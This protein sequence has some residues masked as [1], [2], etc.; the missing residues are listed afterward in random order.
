MKVPIAEPFLGR[1][2]ETAI[3]EVLRTG[4][5]STGPKCA[6]FERALADFVGVKYGRGVNSG[7]SAIE[8]ALLACG[9]T[10]GD[11]VIVPAFTCVATLNPLEHL[12]AR[13]IPVDITLD[14]FGLDPE[15][16]DAAVTP[17]TR[18]IIVVH[19]FGLAAQ[20]EPILALARDRGLVV[21]EDLALGIG[22]RIGERYAGSFGDAACLSF[23]PRKMLT[24]GEGGMVLTNSNKI[25][26]SISEL[27]NYGAS[28]SAW[29]R[30]GGLL[31][32]LP[33]YESAGYNCKLS[34]IQAAVGLQQVKKLPEM[35][36]LRREIASRYDATLAGLDWL[37]LPRELG[38]RMH[39]YQSYVC[40][41]RDGASDSLSSIEAMRL[42]LW[43]HLAQAGVASVQG[44]QDMSAV[45]YYHRKYGWRI[46][47]YPN[48]L[49]AD[50]ASVALPIYPGLSP[51]QQAYV[52]EVL[53][54]F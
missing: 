2:E 4:W 27:R 32:T 42:R 43:Q 1:E 46:G 6:Q 26:K 11:E 48:A 19:L 45:A 21:I 13:P 8:L 12:G 37:V 23:H 52:I 51:D 34:D 40:L 49:R 22:G 25:A 10:P 41:L 53:K 7:S 14:T 39:A 17:R 18:A 36:R 31:F 29:E 54:K 9:V 30:H 24:T 28:I 20:I 15:Q 35:L 5:L 33:E 50:K 38:G 47:S 3:I 44:A 16:V